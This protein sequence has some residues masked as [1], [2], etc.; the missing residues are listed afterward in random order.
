MIYATDGTDRIQITNYNIEARCPK[1]GRFHEIDLIDI[2]DETDT[3]DLESIKV[4]CPECSQRY[5]ES[6]DM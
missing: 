1:C 5:M 2:L 4:F 6:E 3:I